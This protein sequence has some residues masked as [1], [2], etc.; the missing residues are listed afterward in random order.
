MSQAMI[1]K[2]YGDR[3]KVYRR[4]PHAAAP[5]RTQRGHCQERNQQAGG[6][7]RG[8]S[9]RDPAGAC[10]RYVADPKAHYAGEHD[11]RVRRPRLQHHAGHRSAERHGQRSERP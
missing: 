6:G 9:H 10:R 5:E 11:Q 3:D 8:T 1:V 4:R 7:H 2:G